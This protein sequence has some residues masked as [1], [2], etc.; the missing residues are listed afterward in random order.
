M[1][2]SASRTKS[3]SFKARCDAAPALFLDLDYALSKVLSPKCQFDAS[4]ATGGITAARSFRSS[5]HTHIQLCAL[6]K[7]FSILS[8]PSR[9]LSSRCD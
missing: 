5:S 2:S 1:E 3:S 4:R 8:F 6:F 7:A 9:A